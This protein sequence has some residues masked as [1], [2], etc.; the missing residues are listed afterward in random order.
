VIR[1]LTKNYKF[2]LGCLI[3]KYGRDAL[4]KDVNEKEER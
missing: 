3:R 4:V 1:V 2:K